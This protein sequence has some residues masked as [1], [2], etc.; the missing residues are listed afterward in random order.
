VPLLA[1]SLLSGAIQ[2]ELTLWFA[3][4][5]RALNVVGGVVL[6]AIA[7]YDLAENW[8]TLALYYG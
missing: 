1:L 8:D 7:I 3:R 4:H 6:I 5:R 2:R